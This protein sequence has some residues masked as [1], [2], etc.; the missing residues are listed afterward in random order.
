[1]AIPPTAPA[2]PEVA[3]KKA[4]EAI[5]SAVPDLTKSSSGVVDMFQAAPTKVEAAAVAKEKESSGF[6]DLFKSASVVPEA[7]ST[8]AQEASTEWFQGLRFQGLG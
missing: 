4:V 5:S 7:L 1:M 2:V 6:F 3:N 8:T